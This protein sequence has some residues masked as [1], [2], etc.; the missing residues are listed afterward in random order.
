ML[1]LIEQTLVKKRAM[2]WGNCHVMSR[3]FVVLSDS[4]R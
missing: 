2:N 4:D 3:M 1:P